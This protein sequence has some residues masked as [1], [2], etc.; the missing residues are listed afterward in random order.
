[1]PDRPLPTSSD[2]VVI[3]AGPNGLVAANLLADAG[4]EVVVFES[5]PT[6]GGAVRS[7]EVTAP[8][9]VND[10]FSAFYP[11]GA[12]S[13]VLAGLG[14]EEYGL[15]WVH[16][17]AVLAHPT[18]DGPA[19]ILSRDLD[20]TAASL[21]RF[22]PGDGDAWR[23]LYREWVDLSAP[24]LT[25]LFTPFP[26]VRGTARLLARTK[27]EGTI[28]LARRAVLPVRTM[29][30]EEF[31]GAGGALLLAG[32]AL[33]ADLT[34]ESTL[35]GFYGWL[36]AS[37]GQQVGYPVPEGGARRLTDALV[38]RLRSRGGEVV[39]DASVERVM[40]DGDRAVGV[41]LEA[42]PVGRARQAVLADVVA[43]LLYG[44]L[45]GHDLLP[46]RLR[47]DMGRFEYGTGSVKV[48]WA[49]DGPVPW[50]DPA[51]NRAGTVHLVDS[52]DDLSRYG[53]ELATGQIPSDPFL[54]FG[55]MTT[56]D[57][58]RSPAGTE[59]AWAYTHVPW[60]VRGD[61]GGSLEGRWDDGEAHAFV[62]RIEAAVERRA[63]G[64]RS[65]IL[66]RHVFT[67][68]TF[69][70]ANPNLVGGSINGGTAQ[71]HQQLVFRPV[72]GLGRPETPVRDLYLASASAHPGGGVHGAC[73]ANAARAALAHERFGRVLW[74]ALGWRRRT[75][76][77]IGAVS[78]QL[79]S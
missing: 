79:P 66:A 44:K 14:L 9:F 16:A 39:C 31:R 49:L 54:L 4:W 62:A 77:E 75:S 22:A 41:R 64:F 71:L 73:G 42:G 15:R 26:P 25:A 57:P 3:G 27:L 20:E 68:A 5:Q 50:A 6:P 63:P 55:Q 30:Q 24:L 67:P 69:E 40:L 74:P 21:D 35:S 47:R 52:L 45:I 61:A 36:L 17:P 37:L 59:T 13:P 18:P 1:V 8:G 7:A 51:V 32:N 70:N 10:L 60:R 38:A 48:D 23:R 65:K 2:A 53:Y 72:P 28:R 56:A 19:V 11:L 58:S 78:P 43:P 34:P 12:A 33:H 29:A 46:A 76:G